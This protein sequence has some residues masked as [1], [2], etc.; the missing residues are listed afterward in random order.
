MA[1]A[2]QLLKQDENILIVCHSIFSSKIFCE[3]MQQFCA[4]LQKM[5]CLGKLESCQEKS[6]SNC[7]EKRNVE[8][9]PGDMRGIY[10]SNF[11][12]AL[13]QR[14]P[15]YS[16]VLDEVSHSSFR[17]LRREAKKVRSVV[18]VI[19]AD[20]MKHMKPKDFQGFKV[21]KLTSNMRNTG[22]IYN[23]VKSLS[24]ENFKDVQT[25]TVRGIKPEFV[26]IRPKDVIL[27]LTEALQA[28]RSTNK[29]VIILL[30][31]YRRD[32]SRYN[33]VLEAVLTEVNPDV[34]VLYAKNPTDRQRFLSDNQP[35]GCLIAE[36]TEFRGMEAKCVIVLDTHDFTSKIFFSSGHS[37]NMLLRATNQ[38][39]IVSIF[40]ICIAAARRP[41]LWHWRIPYN[42]L[43]SQD[44]QTLLDEMKRNG[45]R[46]GIV[47]DI[48]T[49]KQ[50]TAGYKMSSIVR[51]SMIEIQKK[52]K[53]L[54]QK[55]KQQQPQGDP[56]NYFSYS[57]HISRIEQ[58]TK[59]AG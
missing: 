44:Y 14:K 28:L 59:D 19:S 38:L 36:L 1:K 49:I 41:D 48:E 17:H 47:I 51:S 58:L 11:F 32:E 30:R 53:L 20:S 43:H 27:G 57:N 46:K 7:C 31:H 8:F 52:L 56:N 34:P 22:Q 25:S 54:Y 50:G 5:S 21:I 16:L 3:K 33:S 24:A 9:H 12:D 2:L 35:T 18:C 26:C 42:N 4:T 40:G 39:I 13:I 6:N 55:E 29:Y 15:N 10:P 37:D 23:A 45:E